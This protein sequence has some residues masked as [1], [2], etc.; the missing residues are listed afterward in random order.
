MGFRFKGAHGA[1]EAQ[2]YG[3]PSSYL[4]DDHDGETHEIRQGEGGEQGDPLMPMLYALGQ[5]QALRSVES[6]LRPH[7][8]LLAFHDDVF[9][10]AQPER[11][12]AVHR[13]LGE[14]LWQHSRI[15]INAGKTQIW[16]RGGH[17]PS[18]Y[19]TLLNEARAINPHA[20]VW[21]G[22]SDRPPEERAIRVLGTPLGTAEYVRSQLDATEA[23]HQLLLQRSPAVQDLKSAWLLLLFCASPRATFYL[24]VC[25]PDH[26]KLLHVS[27]TFTLGS[28][29][30]PCW[31]NGKTLSHRIGAVFPSTWG[32]WHIVLHVPPSGA[33]GQIACTLSVTE[34]LPAPCWTPSKALQPLL[35][36]C[37]LPCHVIP[38]GRGR[39]RFGSRCW[40]VCVLDRWILTRWTLVCPPHGWQFFAAQASERHFRTEVLCRLSCV[41]NRARLLDF[42]SWPCHLLPS[43]LRRVFAW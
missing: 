29:S 16:N 30:P 4:W 42:P 8:R 34:T 15:R 41:R 25:H 11:I 22:G 19:E 26:S 43:R 36:T 12:V 35:F 40:M 3:N 32:D 23:A 20:E 37:R 9:A 6:R 38:V 7:E 18:G 28:V 31:C 21:F 14:E 10:V 39:V 24:R 33:V 27:M 5:H 2:F 1:R 17:V 13:I